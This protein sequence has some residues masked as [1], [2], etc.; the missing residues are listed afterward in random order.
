M[1][2]SVPCTVRLLS[3][4]RTLPSQESLLTTSDPLNVLTHC[5]PSVVN[6]S[7]VFTSPFSPAW[8]VWISSFGSAWLMLRTM[9][10]GG[11]I[12]PNLLT[13]GF[14]FHL[15]LKFGCAD[16]IPAERANMANNLPVFT[17]TRHLPAAAIRLEYTALL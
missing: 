3:I 7:S 11:G 6:L 2:I 1:E 14:I 16:A 9:D 4:T 13:A 17:S 8:T 5:L 15:P 10:V 12:T